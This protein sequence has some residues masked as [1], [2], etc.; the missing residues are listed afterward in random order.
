[1]EYKY[2]TNTPIETIQRCMQESF[3]DYQLDM[4]YMTIK[5]MSHRNA[6]CRNNPDCSV[7]AFD[8]SKMIGFLN[9]G[10][11]KYNNELVAFDGGTG[12]TKEYRGQ[13]V[14]GK[15]FAKSVEALKQRKVRKFLLEVLQP[16][17]SAIRAYEKEGF[18]ISRNFKCYDIAINNF[19]EVDSELPGMEIK[20]ISISELEKYWY[21][22]KYPTS[23]EHMLS[24]LKAVENDIIIRASFQKNVCM[25]F[26]VYT[27]Y[28]CW[29]TAI[30]INPEYNDNTLM[31]GYLISNL[32]KNIQP[33]RPKISMNNLMEED[34]LNN[35]LIKL[36]FENPVDQYE[37]IAKI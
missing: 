7:G 26:I 18:S 29:I 25:G 8:G 22:I 14:A 30:G 13:G 12:V 35:I 33:S 20:N 19:K 32:F 31:V 1:M 16:N 37:M 2:L 36:G 21:F 9:V 28:L 17:K 6:I 27:P 11:D 24:G 15:M 4:S 5:V 10:I 23:W 3:A 34:K